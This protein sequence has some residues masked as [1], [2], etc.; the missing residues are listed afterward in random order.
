M[1]NFY[2]FKTKEFES[3]IG[4]ET[5]RQKEHREFW[6]IH[7]RSKKSKGVFIGSSE[8]WAKYDAEQEKQKKSKL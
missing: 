2:N 1:K 7:I 4:P 8:G 3:F 6:Y 5:E